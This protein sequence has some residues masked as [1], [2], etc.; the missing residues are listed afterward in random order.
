LLGLLAPG[1]EFRSPVELLLPGPLGNNKFVLSLVH[2]EA[3]DV[4]FVLGRPETRP[5]APFPFTNSWGSAL[6]LALVFFVAALRGASWRRLLLSAAVAA[7]AVPAIFYSLNRGLWGSLVLGGVGIMALLALRGRLRAVVALSLAGAIVLAALMASP[8]GGLF[9]ERLDN[10]HSNNRRSNLLETTVRSVTEG[11]PVVGFGNTRD[12]Q[13]SFSSIAGG[14][15]PD[16]PAC[17][18]PP[19]G[20]QGHVWLVLFS[21]GWFGAAFFLVFFVLALAR[22]AR[23]RTLAETVCT[24]V[25]VFFV[26]Q[27]AI[28]D[29]LG[30]PLL[31]VM[32]AVGLVARERLE[33]GGRPTPRALLTS[34]AMARELRR[35]APA[36]LVLALLGGAAGWYVALL[37][38]D[39]GHAAAVSIAITPSPV[40]LDVGLAAAA[41]LSG[42]RSE[43]RQ[44]TVDTEASL[45][46][47][48]KTLRQAVSRAGTADTQ[49][50][51]SRIALTAHPNSQVLELVVRD[52]NAQRAEQLA[53][54]VAD[55]YL[56]AREA[57]LVNRRGELVHQLDQELRQLKGSDGATASTR[58]L[59]R[60]AIS[61]LRSSSASVG[62]VIRRSDARP[63]GR[64]TEVTITSGVALGLLLGVTLTA[65]R[66]R[67]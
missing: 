39:P 3:A 5:K 61:H 19:L 14:S 62:E 9:T 53:H 44:I 12:L 48:E 8:L 28:Y 65:L 66:R 46:L 23:C 13:G 17:G 2:P 30:M 59:L 38:P 63:V 20:T 67:P 25:L 40:H 42:T 34:A 64:Q 56:D 58:T 52:G 37:R 1:L 32:V 16:C 10:Q 51:R 41:G 49:D 33:N 50:L 57:H 22:S 45:L 24:F 36:M 31:M 6:S 18:V 55:A 29:T 27:L 60:S 35:A 26:A 15:T 47:S 11:S 7:A 21:Q 4:Q 43:P 54:A